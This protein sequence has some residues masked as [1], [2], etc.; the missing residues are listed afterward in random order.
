M[1][2][3]ENEF[4]I[5]LPLKGI[6]QA[7]TDLPDPVFA[8]KMMGDGVA[9]DPVENVVYAPFAGKITQIHGSHHAITIEQGD[10]ELLMHVGLDTVTLKGRGFELHVAEGEEVEAGQALLSFDA[11]L[12]ARE[13]VSVQSAF[14]ITS[15]QHASLRVSP[16]TVLTD[17]SETVFTVP[18]SNSASV[19]NAGLKHKASGPSFSGSVRIVNATGLHARPAARLAV[20]VR[21]ADADVTFTVNGKSCSGSSVTGIMSLKTKLGD[22]LEI[23]A[24]GADARQVIADLIAAVKAGLGEEIIAFSEMPHVEVEEEAPLLQVRS[25]ED[26]VLIGFTASPGRVIGKLVKRDK[27]LPEVT[28]ESIGPAEERAAFKASVKSS[29][30]DLHGI[31]ERLQAKGQDDLAE[32]FNAHIE[33]LSDPELS[34]KPLEEIAKGKG[35]AWSWKLAYEAQAETLARMDD[36]LLA[37]RAADVRDIGVRVLKKLLGVDDG[38]EILQEGTILLQEDITPSEIVALDL[39]KIVGLCT[40]H[41]GSSSHAA[42]IARSNDLPYLVNVEEGMKE[43][44]DGTVLLLDAK[45]G[46][47]KVA[48]DA[49]E[50][51]AFT[52]KIEEASRLAEQY[53]RE[54]HN[55]AITTDGVQIEIAANIGSLEDAEKAIKAGAEAVGLLRSE[56]LYLERLNEP[57]EEEQA[58]K[59]GEILTVMGKDRPVIIRTLDV[60][61]DKPLPYMPMPPEENPFLG[62][63][64]VRIGIERPSILRRQVR[65]ILSQAHKGHARIMYPMIS[66][67]DELR[68]VNALVR[69]EQKT[70]GVEHVEVGIMVEVPSAAVM[71]DKLAADVDFFSVGTNDLTQYVLAI[72]RG[73]PALASRANAL[74]PA[75]LRLI[76]QTV[77]AADAAGKWVGVCGG[78]ASQVEAVPVLIGLGV[79]ELSVSVPALPEVKHTVRTVSA[80]GARKLAQAALDCADTSDVTALLKTRQA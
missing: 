32:V 76:N 74:H 66:A 62:V 30:A 47:I 56:F 67:L 3:P 2:D 9:I 13:C 39:T 79:K 19:A 15:G 10:V 73:H 58:E 29:I 11:D 77:K 46:K 52:R 38:G 31:I 64:G 69:E 59:I 33:L 4:S 50:Q 54:A 57:T 35:A 40:T 16:G 34:E 24:V 63:R 41:G 80:Q 26:G 53:Q 14:V 18:S 70:M 44:E 17:L 60:G 7:L 42:I 12:I 20:E 43:L 71:A 49:E 22:T 5:Q 45:R 61:G 23:D 27:A 65:A 51:A 78:L 68:A 72:D 55:P 6:V 36:P 48:P 75:V 1:K 25:G 8:E 28:R 37:G 21:K